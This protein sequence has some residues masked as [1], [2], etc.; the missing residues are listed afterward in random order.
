[1]FDSRDDH[2]AYEATYR[3][4]AAHLDRRIVLVAT[5]VMAELWA[6]TTAIEAWAEGAS[7]GGILLFQVVGFVLA[8]GFWKA[9]VSRATIPVPAQTELAPA[10]G[11]LA[12]E[13]AA[14]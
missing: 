1:M 12:Q 2:T 6:L 11:A 9:P 10:R 8:I 13:S 14:G 4:E 7:L 5:I 3:A